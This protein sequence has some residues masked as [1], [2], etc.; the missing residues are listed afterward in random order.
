M[1]L[2]ERRCLGLGSDTP[3]RERDTAVIAGEYIHYEAGLAKGMQM[4]HIGRLAVDT[5][6]AHDVNRSLE[7]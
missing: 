2:F 4:Q 5:L 7:T 1:R 6:A 3:R